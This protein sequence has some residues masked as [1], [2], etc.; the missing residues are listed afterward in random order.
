METSKDTL[1]ELA[2]VTSITKW[3]KNTLQRYMRQGLFPRPI[4]V[5]RSNRWSE[6]AIQQWFANQNRKAQANAGWTS[7]MN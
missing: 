2:D 5:G 3:S 1:L 4:R 7:T 6:Q